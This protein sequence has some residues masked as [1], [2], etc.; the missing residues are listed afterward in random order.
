MLTNSSILDLE[1]L[2]H[3]V[4]G[5]LLLSTGVGVNLIF[6]GIVNYNKIKL[7]ILLKGL[8]RI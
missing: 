4:T 6:K 5:I 7:A 2:C 8:V 3:C 1:A